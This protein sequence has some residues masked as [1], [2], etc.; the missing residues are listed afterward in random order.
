MLSTK[1]LNETYGM[2]KRLH[3]LKASDFSRYN[4]LWSCAYKNM[5]IRIEKDFYNNR[6]IY[7]SDTHCYGG[8]FYGSLKDLKNKIKYD[9]P[10]IK[11]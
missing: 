11:E 8:H 5:H 1:E 6:W 3:E 10:N 2:G 9:Y 4:N 7:G